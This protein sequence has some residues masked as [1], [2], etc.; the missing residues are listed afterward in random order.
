MRIFFYPPFKPMD[1]PN[2]SGDQVIARGILDFFRK[3]NHTVRNAS[4]LRSRWI[5]WKPWLWPRILIEQRRIEKKIIRSKPNLWF[6]YHTYY[7]AP[8][9]LGPAICNRT[10][11]PYVIFQGIFSTKRKRDLRTLPGYL[12]NKKALCTAKHVFTNRRED[13]VNL[14]RLLPGSRLTFITP[15]IYPNDFTFDSKGRS[16]LR[17]IWGVGDSPVVLS[18]AMF[19]PGI[20]TRGISWVIR[21]CGHLLRKGISLFLAVA[22][23][24]KGG[25]DLKQLGH[26]YLADR[27]RFIGRIPRKDMNRFYSAGD[28]FAFPGFRE[29]LGMVFLEAQSCGLPVIACDNGGISE[30][31]RT[32]DTGFLVPVDS[33][34]EFVRAI[35]R[36]LRENDLRQEMGTK[37]KDYIRKR[38]DIG[39]NYNHM[40][41][42][43]KEIATGH[44]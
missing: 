41:E 30:V 20:K 35:G 16:E 1:H 12:L 37:A 2:P 5:F 31:V 17:K 28:I 44:R 10:N 23:D 6:T 29:S 40:E 21:A 13:L 11:L 3:K 36:L 39:L 42:I 25:P 7:K 38:H 22:G 8:D 43:L 26:E 14:E 27:I 32:G 19:R 15:G 9:L 34:A 24:G 18:A 4:Y 33:F